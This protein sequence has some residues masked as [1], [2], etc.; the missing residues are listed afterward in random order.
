[1]ARAAQRV[2]QDIAEYERQVRAGKGDLARDDALFALKICGDLLR[3]TLRLVEKCQ[4][5]AAE[6][7]NN[8]FAQQF[9]KAKLVAATALGLVPPKSKGN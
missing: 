5:T 8:E 2:L 4:R 9:G 6:A 3:R 1:M 7:R